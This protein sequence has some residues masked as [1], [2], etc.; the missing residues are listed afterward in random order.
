MATAY[1]THI[2]VRLYTQ[3][4]PCT[5]TP[6][7]TLPPATCVEPHSPRPTARHA[8]SHTVG[9]PS[10]NAW[11]VNIIIIDL[12]LLFHHRPRRYPL[13]SYL[14]QSN[15]AIA[16]EINYYYYYYF[17]LYTGNQTLTVC[18]REKQ[19]EQRLYP[20]IVIMF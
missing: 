7:H 2:R 20:F 1:H 19:N 10:P 12:T 17:L 14:L 6:A 3:L 15:W 5:V 9:R 11:Q 8:C 16:S 18:K 4:L 13:W